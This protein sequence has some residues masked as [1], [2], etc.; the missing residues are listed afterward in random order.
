M[1]PTWSLR[2]AATVQVTGDMAAF[3]GPGVRRGPDVPPVSAYLADGSAVT[4][5][6]PA[7]IT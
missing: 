1:H 5:S 6:R 2:R 4:V 7:R 3:Y